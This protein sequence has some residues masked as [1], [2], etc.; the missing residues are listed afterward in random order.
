[1]IRHIPEGIFPFEDCGYAR[2][3]C[4]PFV[5]QAVALDCLCG[6]GVPRLEIRGAAADVRPPVPCGESRWRFELAPF[7]APVSFAYRFV[8]GHEQTAWF[9]ADVL[10]EAVVSKPIETGSGWLR[11]DERVY[12]HFALTGAAFTS[13]LSDRPA[14]AAGDAPSAWRLEMDGQSLWRLR[15]GDETPVACREIRLGLRADGSAAWQEMALDSTHRHVWGTGERFDSVDQQGMGA[16]GKVVEHFTRQGAWSYLP[17]PFF[18]TDA[19]FGFYRDAGCDVAMRFSGQIRIASQVIPGRRDTWLLGAPAA[20]L[21][22]YIQLTGAPTL[23]PEWAFGLWISANGWRCDAD[24]DEQLEA[25]KKYD[26]PAS[27]LVLEAWSDES[28]FYRWS[29]AWEAPRRMIEKVRRAGLHLVLWQIPV[30]KA[31]GDCPY[32]EAAKRDRDEAVS[33][34]FVVRRADGS[35]YVIPEKWFAGSLLPDFTNSEACAWWFGKREHLLQ[36]GAE[37]F[38]TDGGEFLFGSDICLHDG[39]PGIEAHNVY[40]MQYLRAYHAW[41]RR[42]GVRG[43]LFSRAGY[44]GAQT[45][46]IH[47]AGDQLSTWDELRAQLTAGLSAGLSGVIFWG[48]DIGGFAGELPEAELYLRATAMACFAPVMQW[49]AEPRSGQFYA[50]HDP[51]FNND[52]SP[53][54]LARQQS[55]PEIIEIACAFARLRERLRPYLWAEAQA[56][57]RNARPMMAHLCLDFPSDRRALGCNDEYML[58]RRY[59]VA[60]VVQKGARGRAV[61]L[62]QGKWR[63]FFTNEIVAGGIA[64]EFDCALTEALVFERLETNG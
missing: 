44:A 64:R 15:R 43:V 62:P 51:A 53:W 42:Q 30:L 3:P 19:G 22:A 20:Q 21:A 59:L 57:V 48:F 45:V 5:G 1:M 25:L 55:A 12:L 46:P 40:A 60:P 18:M 50:T 47:W 11:L 37:G 7:R 28:T 27:V 26:C 35:P 16:C 32:P 63:H 13:W 6:D 31:L 34:G 14:A 9:Q 8:C 58:G 29:E 33:K 36:E 39:T 2:K 17:T 38:K 23:P 41:M 49:H 52:R 24:V 54:N 56:C 4:L 10:R 61:Y